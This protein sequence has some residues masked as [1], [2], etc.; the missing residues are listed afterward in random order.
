VEVVIL[1][2]AATGA[3][4]VAGAVVGLL[5]RQPDAVL[6]LATGSSPLL[7]YTE[8][9]AR[10]RRG[11]V[12]FAG[13]QAFLL[14]EYVGLPDGHRQRYAAVIEADFTAHVDL[15]AAS[16]HT[17]DANDAFVEAECRRYEAAI[18]AAGGIDLQLLG[19]GRDGHIGFNEPGS[20]L[21]S[22]TR[23]KTLTDRTR[24]DN[25]RFFGPG[26]E[27]PRHVLT[28]GL[29]TISDARHLV[30]VAAGAH[31]A[32]A[33]AA[34]VEGAV[35]AFCPASV[36]QLHPHVTVVLD[37]PAASGLKLADYFRETFAAKPAWQDI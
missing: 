20:S 19:I 31:K 17:L 18:G 11:E 13:A 9:A 10:Y 3:R 30:L 2:S 4:F 5:R 29:A 28:Q 1:E 37:E 16:L 15:P 32:D 21:A 26:E 14:D 22:R 6:G 12:S 27:V 35:S 34:T 24:E 23:I 25:A 7:V 36:L 8:L 33:I